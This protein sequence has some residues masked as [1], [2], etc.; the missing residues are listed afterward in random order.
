M[1][2]VNGFRIDGVAGLVQL[3][4]LAAREVTRSFPAVA[5]EPP[6]ASLRG[7]QFR[8]LTMVPIEGGRRMSDLAAIANMSKQAMGEF[9]ADLVE[10]GMVSLT[11]DRADGRAKLVSLTPA[12]RRAVEHA[13]AVL[14][15][16]EQHWADR[17]GAEDYRTLVELL[18]RV[19]GVELDGATPD[20]A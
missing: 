12:G 10:I 15:R 11:R 14:R 9:V 3:T 16:V 4:D 6:P 19:A 13:D 17:L 1:F 20:R 8:V 2:T 18:A 5:A 7:S